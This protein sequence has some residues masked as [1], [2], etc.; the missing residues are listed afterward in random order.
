M[1]TS[2][3]GALAP[4]HFGA[5]AGIQWHE[6]RHHPMTRWTAKELQR[7]DWFLSLLELVQQKLDQLTAD[8]LDRGPALLKELEEVRKQIQGWSLSLANPDLSP[9]TRTVLESDLGRA[10]QRGEDLERQLREAEALH[11]QTHKPI[12][13]EQVADRLN[14]LAE[15]L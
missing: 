10:F 6:R 9:A 12:D 2:D 8:R 11:R 14:R 1:T 7:T 15:V 13:P 3:M 4:H 5:R